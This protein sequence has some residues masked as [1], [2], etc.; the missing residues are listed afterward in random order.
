MIK[1]VVVLLLLMVFSL[2]S[3]AEAKIA[4]DFTL[5]SYKGGSIRLADLRGKVV[6]VDFWASWCGPCRKSFPWMNAMHKRYGTK[7]L[8][9]V[10]VNLDREAALA[11]QFLKELPP[12]FHVVFDPRGDVA[13]R[14]GIPGMPSSYIVDRNGRIQYSH[15]GF[16]ETKKADLESRIKA[17]LGK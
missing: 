5:P 12:D 14:Y 7:G 13:K 4:P 11:N 17:M 10:A 6:Y 3:M 15:I 16:T 9:I 1:R 8:V 2:A